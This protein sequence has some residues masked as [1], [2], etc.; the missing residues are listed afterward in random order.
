LF[1]GLL[2]SRRTLSIDLNIEGHFHVEEFLGESS[3]VFVDLPKARYDNL[4]VLLS[5]IEK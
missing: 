3:Y 2:D 4:D 1:N 5:T